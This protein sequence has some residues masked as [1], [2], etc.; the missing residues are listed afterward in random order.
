MYTNWFYYLFTLFITMF[1]FRIIGPFLLP[2]LGIYL[3]YT[4][5]KNRQQIKAM[6]DL[7]KAKKTFETEWQQTTSS[8]KYQTRHHDIEDASYTIKEDN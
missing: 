5:I 1:I 4:L 2:L 3:V 6:N 8:P 7:R